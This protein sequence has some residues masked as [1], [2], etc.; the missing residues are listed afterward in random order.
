MICTILEPLKQTINMKTNIKNYNKE[1]SLLIIVNMSIYCIFSNNYEIIVLLLNTITLTAPSLLIIDL[2]SQKYKE[3]MLIQRRYGE[4]VFEDLTKNKNEEINLNLIKKEYGKLPSSYKEQNNLWY[5][6]Y[7][8]N[9]SNPRILHTHRQYLLARDLN[10]TILII[11]IFT[12]VFII[13]KLLLQEALLNL[14]LKLIF[15]EITELIIILLTARNLQKKFVLSVLIEE[16]YQLNLKYHHQ[17]VS[18]A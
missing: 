7:R 1:I 10:C 11:I 14:Y 8:K 9:E 5:N 3:K 4:I 18:Y 15:V 13:Y 17:D 2:I 12:I 6:I 16:T